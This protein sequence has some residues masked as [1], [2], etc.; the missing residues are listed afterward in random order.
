M[1]VREITDKIEKRIPR[2]AALEWDN[3]GLLVGNPEQEVHRIY[4]ALDATD[5][6]IDH[7]IHAKADM[8]ITH[9]PML[10]SAIRS[11]RADDFV[12]RR[13]MKLVSHG[14]ACYAMHTNYDVCEMGDLAADT[15]GMTGLIPLD[16]SYD[17][18]DIDPVEAAGDG[19]DAISPIRIS[20]SM[21]I[22]KV[23]ETGDA[24]APS[25]QDYAKRVREAF[26]LSHV[27]VFGDPEHEVRRVAIC[28]GSGKSDVDCAL[29]A[30]ADTYVSG[31][32]DHHTGL[33]ALARG[34][35]VIDAGHYGIEHIFIEHMAMT[36]RAQLAQV[37]VLTE[38]MKEPVWL[39]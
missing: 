29:A 17:G 9:H 38:P 32:I 5:Q 18:R 10:Y 39:A 23:G 8:L 4:V 28:P 31:D 26:G 2:Q 30:G 21:G 12:G 15:L 14:I 11:V 16:V 1:K 6:V 36:L 35:A 22:G 25:L 33:D 20:A 27:R 24:I 34:L 7:A 37:D 3:V 19:T 13:V